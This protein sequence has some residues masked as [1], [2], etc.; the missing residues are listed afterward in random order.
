MNI[1]KSWKPPRSY[2]SKTWSYST[3]ILG[4]PALAFVFWP[5]ADITKKNWEKKTQFFKAP[6]SQWFYNWWFGLVWIPIGSPGIPKHQPPRPWTSTCAVL[7][8]KLHSPKNNTKKIATEHKVNTATP[9]RWALSSSSCIKFSAVNF[10]WL[11]VDPTHLKNM[12]VKLD[13][14]SPC[15]GVKTKIFETI[16][17]NHHLVFLSREGIWWKCDV[18][19][20]FIGWF[21]LIFVFFDRNFSTCSSGLWNNFQH[22]LWLD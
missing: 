13:H 9:K 11:L 6:F 1:K 20:W 18:I 19:T 10:F 14:L 21:R 12:L 3:T 2:N 17:W 4:W 8:G 15:F 22:F 16:T 7:K 5:Q